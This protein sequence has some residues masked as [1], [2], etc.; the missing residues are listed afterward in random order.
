MYDNT[1]EDCRWSHDQKSAYHH[2]RGREGEGV[3]PCDKIK[4][5]VPFD[6]IQQSKYLSFAS[7]FFLLAASNVSSQ[8]AAAIPE[9]L[10]TV[11]KMFNPPVII[12]PKVSSNS[13]VCGEVNGAQVVFV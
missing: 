12:I 9:S 10:V 3:L 8:P 2:K 6:P 5:D 11:M 13:Q 4:E 1:E 7:D